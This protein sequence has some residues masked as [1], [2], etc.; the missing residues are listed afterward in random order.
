MNIQDIARLA[1]T[2]KSTVSRVLSNHPY[3]K[4][5]TRQRVL[6]VI[7]AYHYRPNAMARGLA[8]G[9][10]SVI[11][12]LV[13]DVRNPFYTEMTW[14]IQQEL[15]K[16]GYQLF[17]CCSN[18]DALMEKEFYALSSQ[19]SFS[20]MIVVSLVD[21][22][23]F[24]RAMDK[25][26]CPVLLVNQKVEHFPG[27]VLV[28]D[29]Y[30]AG[31][32]AARHLIEQG[33]SKIAIISCNQQNSSHRERR[34]GFISALSA[35]NISLPPAYDFEY[36]YAIGGYDNKCGQRFYEEFMQMGSD[37][38]TAVFCTADIIAV[39]IIEVFRAAGHS[40]PEDLSVI[41]FDDIPFASLDSISLTTI[42]QPYAKIGRQA[43]DMILNR[44]ENNPSGQQM[45]IMDCELIVRG[46]TAKKAT[47]K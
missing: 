13:S 46:S 5:E 28:T 15:N 25:L 43:V 11:A 21:E 3:V 30:Q 22:T 41:G 40:V 44:I 1:G 45:A 32:I 14:H 42:R 37:A 17:L 23:Q 31:Y 33:H 2:S 6:E 29:N 10:M 19:Y 12:L 38:P 18:Y 24:L 27:D 16:R 35:Y 47:A 34:A 39:S 26:P 9:S 8:N 20:G 7:D 4:E 36:D